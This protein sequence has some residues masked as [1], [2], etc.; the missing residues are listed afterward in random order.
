[1]GAQIQP[2][3]QM[4]PP[5]DWPGP[6]PI[7]L[8]L[9]DL[10][11]ASAAKEWWYVNTHLTST[12]GREYSIFAAFFRADI[13]QPGSSTKEYGHFLVWGLVDTFNGRFYS[14]TLL[15]P[16]S[17]Q[18]GLLELD[19]GYGPRD[20]KISS[21]LREI[22]AAGRI[23]LP[24][25]LMHNA[26]VEVQRLDM[27]LDGN[28]FLKRGDGSYEL[29]LR[30]DSGR[31][32]CLLTFKLQKPVVRHGEGGVVRGLAGED[33]FY[34]FS[35]R[36]SVEGTLTLDGETQDVH[37]SGWYD[38]EFGERRESGGRNETK[39]AWNW[40]GAQLDNGYEINAYDLVQKDNPEIGQ[41]RWV[42]VV[43]PAGKAHAY[44]DF[45]FAA[46]NPWTSTRTFNEYPTR[47]HL[48]CAG[49]RLALEI[50]AVFPAQEI[51]TLISL[52]AF[53]EGRVA[54]RGSKRIQLRRHH[55]RVPHFGR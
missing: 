24:D 3:L 37:G 10:P 46:S 7:D 55:R 4:A 22:L 44:T 2:G 35:P 12:D 11:H 14:H 19:E 47:Y 50:D 9:H 40:I 8:Q 54:I 25:R 20:S 53:W 17:P 38:H 5:K 43:D 28:R 30:G 13:S 1:M 6:G 33:M 45:V 21:A 26:R 36:C 51:M 39:I 31:E 49:A 16:A 27:D 29:E 18:T 42:I 34:Y 23:P 48:Q 32:T 41:G 52:P 15:D